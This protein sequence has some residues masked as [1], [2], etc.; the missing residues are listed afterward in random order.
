MKARATVVA[1]LLGLMAASV[2]DAAKIVTL[3]QWEFR[4]EGG[5][6]ESVRVPHDWAISGPFDKEIDKQVVAI[7]QNGEKVASEKTGR[8]GNPR[9]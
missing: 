6:W 2:C 4:R 7:V 9:D 1:I 3:S 8:T 5:V